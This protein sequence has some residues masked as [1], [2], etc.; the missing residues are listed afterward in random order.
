[1]TRPQI[2]APPDRVAYLRQ[3]QERKRRLDSDRLAQADAFALIGYQPICRPRVL[4]QQARDRGE[5]VPVPEPCGGCPQE[6]FHQAT[7]DAVLY[8]G[9]AGGGKALPWWRRHCA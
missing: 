1:M 2:Q 4:A 6:L 9:S 8:G 5:N 3:L 7:E